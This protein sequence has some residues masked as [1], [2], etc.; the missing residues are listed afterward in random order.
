MKLKQVKAE[1]VGSSDKDFHLYWGDTDWG[2]RGFPQTFQVN[3]GIGHRSR[4][5]SYPSQAI[6]VLHVSVPTKKMKPEESK[7]GGVWALPNAKNST[8]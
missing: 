6:L 1:Q 4:S 8:S 7:S 3:S 2:F 5:L